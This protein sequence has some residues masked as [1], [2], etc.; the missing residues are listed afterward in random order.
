M[1]FRRLPV[2]LALYKIIP[3]IKGVKE[4]AFT[5]FFGPIGIGALFYLQVALEQLAEWGL[6]TNQDY[7]CLMLRSVVYFSILTSIIVHGVGIPILR[8]AILVKTS[9]KK[10]RNGKLSR[11][12]SEPSQA[13]ATSIS[14]DKCI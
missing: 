14:S 5:G 7:L 12:A 9:M 13:Y 8:L 6:D 3:E 10:R 2:I 4:A 11:S 1:L